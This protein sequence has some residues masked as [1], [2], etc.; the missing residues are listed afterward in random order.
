M[1]AQSRPLDPASVSP[2]KAAS[3]SS[4]IESTLSVPLSSSP[5]R[6]ISGLSS[7]CRPTS[8]WPIPNHNVPLPSIKTPYEDHPP[9]DELA[10][11]NRGIGE[12]TFEEMLNW[13][14]DDWQW[15][16]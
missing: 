16:L 6:E 10:T 2:E 14:F 12:M 3:F 4:G 5:Y 13:D 8:E 15:K 7:P 11:V 9:A 1:I